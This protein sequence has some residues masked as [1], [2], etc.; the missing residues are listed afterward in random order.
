MTL[1]PNKD[2]YEALVSQRQEKVVVRTSVAPFSV[3][4]RSIRLGLHAL[5]T[6]QWSTAA[7]YF[8]TV[9]S[10]ITRCNVTAKEG[11]HRKN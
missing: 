3:M 7:T 10:T 8:K 11:E 2:H 5:C 4:K 6:C 9:M 1:K